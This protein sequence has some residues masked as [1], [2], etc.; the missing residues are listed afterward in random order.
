MV[1]LSLPG[2]VR[3]RARR[4]GTPVWLSLMP[5]MSDKARLRPNFKRS[6]GMLLVCS[7]L[8]ACSVSDP[9]NND[10]AIESSQYEG[11]HSVFEPRDL[12][13]AQ[14]VAR[15][16]ELSFDEEDPGRPIEFSKVGSGKVEGVREY[17]GLSG[18]IY[19]LC[20]SSTRVNSATAKQN[21]ILA[22]GPP[23]AAGDL[24][25]DFILADPLLVS[26]DD[27]A[28]LSTEDSGY[29]G[30]R[31]TSVAG[32]LKFGSYAI[33]ANGRYSGSYGYE[34]RGQNSG[35]VQFY[36]HP[37]SG[38]LAAVI[39]M[40]YLDRGSSKFGRVV[41]F[42][43]GQG[44][45]STGV[46]NRYTS[47][48]QSWNAQ[49]KRTLLD[50]HPVLDADR[51]PLGYMLEHAMEPLSP[52]LLPVGS[53]ASYA[54]GIAD[55]AYV[56][57][58]QPANHLV[59]DPGQPALADNQAFYLRYA[60]A[61]APQAAAVADASLARALD[62]CQPG[63]E[64]ALQVKVSN[65]RTQV[66]IA[67][68]KSYDVAEDGSFGD[69]A[70]SGKVRLFHNRQ[71]H[72]LALYRYRDASGNHVGLRTNAPG[73][74]VATDFTR[75]PHWHS[76]EADGSS[77]PYAAARRFNKLAW[78][79]PQDEIG[80]FRR[81]TRSVAYK[82][83]A[84]A[85]CDLDTMMSDWPLEMDG[86]L[87]ANTTFLLHDS[88]R[89][90]DAAGRLGRSTKDVRHVMNTCNRITTNLDLTFE[91]ADGAVYA[92]L[93]G[94]GT[95]LKSPLDAQGNFNRNGLSGHAD[96]YLDADNRL[97]IAYAFHLNDKVGGKSG[98]GIALESA[99]AAHGQQNAVWQQ[100]DGPWARTFTSGNSYVALAH[101][102]NAAPMK[103]RTG[104]PTRINRYAYLPR[105]VMAW[106]GVAGQAY[107]LC[108]DYFYVDGVYRNRETGDFLPGYNMDNAAEFRREM[109]HL[110]VRGL[111]VTGEVTGYRFTNL[112]FNDFA[113]THSVQTCRH[114]DNPA[115]TAGVQAYG[116]EN[117]AFYARNHQGVQAGGNRGFS[118]TSGWGEGGHADSALFL[119]DA[120][121]AVMAYRYYLDSNDESKGIA[122]GLMFGSDARDTPVVGSD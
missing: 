98:R 32:V 21:A 100:A 106:Q 79:R 104:W 101:A 2:R 110:I 40:H 67:Q 57:C 120:N 39:S 107:F 68:Q 97:V 74:I 8:A 70:A 114:S 116:Y 115:G 12:Y 33:D 24:P 64:M 83:V 99:P 11:W 89:K 23:I 59:A 78:F 45:Q 41:L 58:S 61:L 49:L 112:T 73:E 80:Q 25:P 37:Q 20:G 95:P 113:L 81:V 29:L 109:P 103:T 71:G 48:Y 60:Q 15:S 53:D 85:V 119:T 55:I 6:V 14:G 35:H 43:Q 9:E 3:S 38:Q 1:H 44:A 108:E 22:Y 4:L 10:L 19:T 42:D 105:D 26:C 87:D 56:V 94:I 51:Q 122:Y 47:G 77:K 18:L 28:A 27:A 121:E 69:A 93:S 36:R 46:S 13:D 66:I 34:S 30:R 62:G 86:L 54:Q 91:V 65:Q 90:L 82:D 72:L 84:F 88:L 117:G 111:I 92:V 16:Y 50:Y 52:T 102:N 7:M 63:N 5:C 118:F 75:T 17:A 76:L 96:F 31:I